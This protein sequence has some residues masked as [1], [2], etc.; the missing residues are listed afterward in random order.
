MVQIDHGTDRQHEWRIENLRGAIAMAVE[1]L[2]MLVLVNGGAAIGLLSF[3]GTHADH[4]MPRA[5]LF[6]FGIGVAMASLA[7]V[8]GYIAQRQVAVEGPYEIPYAKVAIG[9]ALS[10]SFAFCGGV[11]LASCRV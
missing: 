3:F 9:L 6:V 1:S 4:A 7:A 11:V 8:F 2:K 5:A 10:S